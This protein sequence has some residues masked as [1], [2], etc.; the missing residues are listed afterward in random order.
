MHVFLPNI[1][2]CL[3]SCHLD[4]AI[5]RSGCNSYSICPKLNSSTFSQAIYGRQ[6]NAPSSQDVYILIS[7][8]CEYVSLHGKGELTLQLDSELLTINPQVGKLT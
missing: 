4:L 5:W 2:T 7:A 6:N 8:T 3:F 1:Q